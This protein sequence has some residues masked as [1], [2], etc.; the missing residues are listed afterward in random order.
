VIRQV[1]EGF[2]F[3][4]AGCHMELDRVAGERVLDSI[5]RSVPTQWRAKAAELAA[6]AAEQPEISL[7]GF[8]VASGLDL[9]DV[10][11]GNRSWSDLRQL[12]RL[13]IE[14]PG[15]HEEAL[16][17]ACGRLLHVDDAERLDAWSA[18]LE[19]DTIPEAA[20]LS[21]RERRL[22]RMLSAPLVDQVADKTTHLQAGVEQLWSHPQI[23]RE[24]VDLFATLSQ[25]ITHLSVPLTSPPGIPL[26]IHARYTRLE[27]LAACGVGS[28]ATVAPWQ[29]GVYYDKASAVDLFAFT[30]DKTSGQ[31]SP[32]TRFKDY[33]ISR[34]L[35][36]WQSQSTTRADSPTGRRYQ[37][38]EALG[39]SV[40]FFARLNA[41]DRAFHF[42]GPASYVSH[43][44]ELPM[45]MTWRLDRPLPGDLFQAFAAAVA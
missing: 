38:H 15:P 30:L 7:S 18:W 1:E 37:Q 6:L 4:P 23:R 5:K 16:R 34:D 40:L 2:P 31:F 26:R 41:N 32:T 20:R 13:S 8:L 29:T 9:D 28:G 35:I 3:L 45:S 24:L 12:A 11:A 21:E 36:H 10:Y 17:R 19:S 27:I 33:A 42:L 43:V 14:E 25:R 39:S 22:L 44:G